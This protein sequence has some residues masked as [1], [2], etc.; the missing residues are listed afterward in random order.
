MQAEAAIT[1]K[2]GS[3]L[4]LIGTLRDAF[5]L[6]SCWQPLG[7][8]CSQDIW[9]FIVRVC[10]ISAGACLLL[11]LHA[12]GNRCAVGLGLV[13][14]TRH[15]GVLCQLSQHGLAGRRISWVHWW[16]GRW[17]HLSSCCCSY[18]SGKQLTP[19][20][21]TPGS[22]KTQRGLKQPVHNYIR[23]ASAQCLGQ[24]GGGV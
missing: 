6:C 1:D 3:Q 23:V 11:C 10:R 15:N 5:H 24:R 4:G 22:S 14:V 20:W 16:W 21:L 8:K 17:R 2:A 18:R 13:T 19:V 7:S 12:R 9:R